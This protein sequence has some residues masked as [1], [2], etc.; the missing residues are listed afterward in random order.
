MASRLV[1]GTADLRDD[2]LT[3]SLLDDFHAGGGRRLD[4]ANHYRDGES[5]RAI[6]NWLAARGVRDEVVLYGKGCHPPFCEPSLVAAEVERA[7]RLLRVDRLDAFLLHRDR[8]D[9][10]VQ[11]FAAPLLEQVDAGRIAGFGV[12]NWTVERFRALARALGD[13]R[14][15]L[16]AFSNHFSLAEMVAAPWEGCLGTTKAELAALGADR[17]TV[18][19]WAALA[20]GYLAGADAPGWDT[21]ENGARRRR[22]RELAL[23]LGA[24]PAAVAL[25]YVLHQPAHVLAVVGPSSRNQLAEALAATELRLSPDRLAWLETGRPQ[26]GSS[27]TVKP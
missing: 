8:P 2:R 23:E 20:T 6:G 7:L 13:R 15:A 10:P 27:G 14:D 22:A 3:V 1:L 9:L 26:S 4:V 12:S 24:S 21:P 19:A 18:L 25:S 17:V 16:V 5:Q 11:A